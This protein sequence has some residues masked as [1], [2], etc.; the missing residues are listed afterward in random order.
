MDTGNMRVL[1]VGAEAG[2]SFLCARLHKA[3]CL[4][5]VAPTSAEGARLLSR[6]LFD[7]VLCSID[8]DG[9]DVLADAVLNSSASL[10]RY[11]PVEDGCWWVSAVVRGERCT[12]KAFRPAEFLKALETLSV[13]PGK[14]LSVCA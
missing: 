2:L 6:R 10:F 13:L 3:G 1:L 7:L 12:G 5:Q 9:Y 8:V 4:C 11:L 14:R